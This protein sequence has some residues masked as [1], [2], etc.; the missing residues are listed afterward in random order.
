MHTWQSKHT[1]HGVSAAAAG[2]P[3][4][5]CDLEEVVLHALQLKAIHLALVTSQR[6]LEGNYEALRQE[7]V[8]THDNS[9]LS[10]HMPEL[11]VLSMRSSCSSVT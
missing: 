10:A 8:R 11:W 4:S 6:K 7:R 1:V 3:L 9:L 2:F 5:S